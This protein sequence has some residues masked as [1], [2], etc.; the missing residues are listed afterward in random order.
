M[1][2]LPSFSLYSWKLQL[3]LTFRIVKLQHT[4]HAWSGRNVLVINHPVF[5][6]WSST[7][8]QTLFRIL[9]RDFLAR[10]LVVFLVYLVGFAGAFLLALQVGR[11][12]TEVA[13]DQEGREVARA[14][15]ADGTNTSTM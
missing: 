3:P 8:I 5:H 1:Y 13:H 6:R 14:S 10:F 7:Y 9:K 12:N 15:G 4:V 11:S 2:A